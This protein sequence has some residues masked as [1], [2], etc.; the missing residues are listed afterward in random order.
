MGAAKILTIQK[1]GETIKSHELEGEAVLGRGEGCVI[2]LEDRAVSRQHAVFRPTQEGVQVERKSE[3]APLV[4]NGVECTQAVILKEGDVISIGPYLLRL[5]DETRASGETT[6]PVREELGATDPVMDSE[7]EPQVAGGTL[8]ETISQDLMALGPI[9]PPSPLDSLEPA[10]ISMD[11]PAE[12][13]ITGEGA[14]ALP[15]IDGLMAEEPSKFLNAG[16]GIAE[17]LPMEDLGSPASEDASTKLISPAKLDVRLVF[18]PGDANITEFKLDKEEISIGRG[19]TCDIVLNDKKSSR[20]HAVIR[21]SGATFV[22]HDLGSANGTLVNGSKV[23][24]HELAGDDL[25]RIGEIE[26]R[27]VATSAE[28]AAQAQDFLPVVDEPEEEPGGLD[29]GQ[30]P[31]AAPISGVPVAGAAADQVAG[32]VPGTLPGLGAIPGMSGAGSQRKTT[33]V[34][35]FKAQPKPRQILILLLLAGLFLWLTEEEEQPKQKAKGASKKPSATASVLPGTKTFA[36]LTSEEQ[37]F[38]E[39]QYALGFDHY[40]SKKYKDSLYEL[41]R[42]FAL[43]NDYKNAR[44]IERYAKEGIRK[45]EAL[46]EEQRKKEEEARLKA[47]VAQLIEETR[48]RMA[49]KEYEQARELFAEVLTLDPENAQVAEWRKE[50]EAFEEELQR[51]AQEKMVV[52]QINQRAWEVLNEGLALKKQGKCHSAMKVL[53]TVGD[54]GASDLKPVAKAGVAIQG[55]QKWI[56]DRRDPVL[57]EA[58]QAEEGGEFSRA[59]GLYEKAAKIDPPHPAGHAGMKRIRGV[60]HERAKVIYTEAVLAESYSDFTTAEKKFRECLEAA[61]AGDIYHD[62]ARRKLSRYLKRSE[63]TEP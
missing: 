30:F 31:M 48:E 6:A 12:P 3:F 34:E 5:N 44:E 43:I 36:M 33:L 18:S 55:C 13:E 32:Q 20:K 46:E 10:V 4:V 54:L 28:Y 21:R 23:R 29:G 11:S 15:S 2:R 9:G 59:Y 57:A 35:K 61:P 19:S 24:E 51:K 7:S 62:R 22:L 60:L 56:K 53:G 58:K 63:S 38:V 16:V 27:F 37:R 8:V 52:E 1:N 17:A 39:A 47:R 25:I 40:K 42:I 45:L 26:F 14:G 41:N 50:I 49:N